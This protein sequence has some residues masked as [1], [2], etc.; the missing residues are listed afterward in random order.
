MELFD[1][2]D[3]VKTAEVD[4]CDD[5]GFNDQTGAFDDQNRVSDDRTR[6]FIG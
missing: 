2:D 5:S 3:S 4:R 1:K 6:S